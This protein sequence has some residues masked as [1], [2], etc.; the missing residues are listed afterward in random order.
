MEPHLCITDIGRQIRTLI[1]KV[2]MHLKKLRHC[3]L[4]SNISAVAKTNE[5]LKF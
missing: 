4:F 5:V 3:K 2:G 1:K